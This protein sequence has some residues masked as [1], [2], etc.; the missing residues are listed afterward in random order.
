[1]EYTHE[2]V[3]ECHIQQWGYMASWIHYSLIKTDQKSI[4]CNQN[5]QG[6]TKVMR[7]MNHKKYPVKYIL[8][9][10]YIMRGM[11]ACTV[12]LGTLYV[13]VSMDTL[14][15]INVIEIWYSNKYKK[16]R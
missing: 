14:K 4:P 7:T 16:F 6:Q 3:A 13:S 9:K 12:W 10:Y 11:Y 1:M 2:R 5:T 8:W 15:S